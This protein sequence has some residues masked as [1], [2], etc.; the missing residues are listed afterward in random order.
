MD[1]IRFNIRL[2]DDRLC[3]LVMIGVKADR[4]KE[5]VAGALGFWSALRD[6]WPETTPQRDW[7]RKMA[8]VLDKLPKRL[9]PKAK[10]ALREIMY[11]PTK[12]AAEKAIAAFVSEFEAKYPKAAACLV[13][14]RE[15]LLAFFDFPGGALAASADIEPDRVA[16]RDGASAAAGDEGCRLAHEGPADGVQAAGDGAAAV[17]P[18]ERGAPAAFGKGRCEVRRRAAAGPRRAGERGRLTFTPG[19]RSTTFDNISCRC[20]KA[21]MAASS[22]AAKP[23]VRT[24]KRSPQTSA[25]SVAEPRREILVEE[26]FHLATATSRRSRSAA[27]ARHAR[28]S[29]RVR[30]GKS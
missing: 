15:A 8:N 29:S 10:R 4:T 22:A 25:Q 20:A 5:L 6:V 12:A 19:T 21:Q 18:P 17:A 3:T 28:M 13:A 9:R 1:G 14:D 2:E 16:V 7:C 11:A 26:Q 30:S 24:W 27:N 23:T